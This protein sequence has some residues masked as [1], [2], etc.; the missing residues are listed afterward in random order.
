MSGPSFNYD[1]F[2]GQESK[3][4][5]FLLIITFLDFLDFGDDLSTQLAQYGLTADAIPY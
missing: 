1:E 3:M 5:K 4:T 2:T